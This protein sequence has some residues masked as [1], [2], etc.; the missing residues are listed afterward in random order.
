MFF[1]PTF[2]LEYFKFISG[3]EIVLRVPMY[4]LYLS[5]FIL[6]SSFGGTFMPSKIITGLTKV[7]GLFGFHQFFHLFYM[8]AAF[9]PRLPLCFK[10]Y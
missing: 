6:A 5:V 7:Q 3:S 8:Y 2:F 9:E 4:L 10:V 1:S